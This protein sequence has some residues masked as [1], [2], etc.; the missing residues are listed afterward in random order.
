[1]VM[2]SIRKKASNVP[3]AGIAAKRKSQLSA[4]KI[5]LRAEY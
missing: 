3:T 5:T 4:D 2:T 1:M